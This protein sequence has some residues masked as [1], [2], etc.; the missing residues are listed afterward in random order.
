VPERRSKIYT[1]K[2]SGEFRIPEGI[3]P[4]YVWKKHWCQYS[5]ANTEVFDRPCS[6]PNTEPAIAGTM[7]NPEPQLD[8][9]RTFLRVHARNGQTGMD[10]RLNG[11]GYRRVA[12][13]GPYGLPINHKR[14]SVMTLSHSCSSYHSPSPTSSVESQNH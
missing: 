10:I 7:P 5:P 4:G 6:N 14:L 11:N 2:I 1:N 9:S 12:W 8:L 13:A 3:F